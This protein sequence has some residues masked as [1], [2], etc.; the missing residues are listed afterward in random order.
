MDI[1]HDEKEY[2]YN[3][4][5]GTRRFAQPTDGPVSFVQGI[6]T[7]FHD[8][9]SVFGSFI[10]A[11]VI[12]PCPKHTIFAALSEFTSFASQLVVLALAPYTGLGIVGF[13]LCDFAFFNLTT[14]I[15]VKNV[16]RSQTVAAWVDGGDLIENQE[17]AANLPSNH[18]LFVA[19]GHTPGTNSCGSC[20][21]V[22]T[23][24]VIQD[25]RC[26][27]YNG[28]AKLPISSWDIVSCCFNCTP[29]DNGCNG[30][31]VYKAFDWFDTVGI[32]T[33]GQYG[34]CKPYEVAPGQSPP[35]NRTCKKSCQASYTSPTYPNDKKKGGYNKIFY[36]N[37][38]AAQAEILANGS[39]V[40]QFDVY[41]DFYNYKSG[42]YQHVSGNYVGGH[43]L[44]GWGVDNG[45]QYW[46][47]ANSWGVNWGDKG[48]FKIRRG[49]NECNFEKWSFAGNVLKD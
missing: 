9:V 32:V 25:R 30:G 41:Y 16:R 37:T 42:I 2:V 28:T 6:L 12:R 14:E 34:G 24:S 29:S 49:N 21:A 15:I 11:S 13:G 46:L 31:Y 19:S 48:F 20:W 7:E 33:G 44:I 45:T 27:L 5:E 26:I 22:S 3:E 39:I 1:T 38:A 8:K 17:V 36:N 35:A 47:A 4:E 43:G 10:L 23:A 40:A 18:M